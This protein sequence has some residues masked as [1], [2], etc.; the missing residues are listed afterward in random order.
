MSKSTAFQSDR[1][2]TGICLVYKTRTKPKNGKPFYNAGTERFIAN[3][4]EAEV[5]VTVRD[6]RVDEDDPLLGIVHLQLGQ[7]FQDRAQI[8]GFYPITGGIG[9]GRIRISMVWRSVQ[10]QAPRELLGWDVGTLEVKPTITAV[11]S[12]A[13]ACEDSVQSWGLSARHG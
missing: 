4:H 1:P 12:A 5:F 11:D 6:A 2:S 3:W 7:V 13:D 8:N 9:H 10:L